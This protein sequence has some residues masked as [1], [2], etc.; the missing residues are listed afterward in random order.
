MNNSEDTEDYKG[1]RELN[2]SSKCEKDGCHL[3]EKEIE[4]DEDDMGKVDS[5]PFVSV[6]ISYLEML[7]GFIKK[8]CKYK[9]NKIYM[10][11]N[12]RPA[13]FK[14]EY[15]FDIDNLRFSTYDDSKHRYL[16][17]GEFEKEVKNPIEK[18]S[19]CVS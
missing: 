2:Y 6:K 5:N 13:E 9:T 8:N 16:T 14:K 19:K 4:I 17:I 15:Y 11:T 7:W 3:V 1:I 10:D 18:L 12:N